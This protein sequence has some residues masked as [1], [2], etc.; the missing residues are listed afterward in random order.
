MTMQVFNIWPH[1]DDVQVDANGDLTMG[2]QTIMSDDSQSGILQR[3]TGI[4]MSDWM[5]LLQLKIQSLADAIV[6]EASMLAVSSRISPFGQQAKKHG[7]TEHLGGYA[8][9]DSSVLI[10]H[11]KVDDITVVI[12]LVVENA[13]A[14]SDLSADRDESQEAPIL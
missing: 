7:W 11:S 10:I 4:S 13:C 14:Q 3:P 6:Q 2:G 12:A 5:A 9:S 1:S 8:R